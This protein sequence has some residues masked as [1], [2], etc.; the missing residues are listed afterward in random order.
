[1]NAKE[2]NIEVIEPKIVSSK[3]GLTTT[4]V[5]YK[6]CT[7]TVTGVWQGQYVEETNEKPEFELHTIE[8]GNND[9]TDLLDK[10]EVNEIVVLVVNK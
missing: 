3:K 4:T 7:F 8:I 1:M 6:N 5:N 2:H 9:L 10:D